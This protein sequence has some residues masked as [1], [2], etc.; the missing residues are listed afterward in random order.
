MRNYKI[1]AVIASLIIGFFLISIDRKDAFSQ[2][3]EWVP[4]NCMF[5]PRDQ[6]TGG[7]ID[8]KIY[9]FGGNG[10]PDGFNL[11]TTEMFDPTTHI[12]TYKSPNENNGG[13]GVE[14]LSGAVLN[15]VPIYYLPAI[16]YIL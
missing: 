13:Q 7:V 10:N 3:L 4:E 5:T 1:A 11:K 6:F 8:G 12:W 15:N 16:L 14:E 2:D 9:V